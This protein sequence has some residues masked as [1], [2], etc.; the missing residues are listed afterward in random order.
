MTPGVRR[1]G[2]PKGT[3]IDD[4]A[5]LSRIGELM[6]ADPELK[7][8]TA[9]KRAGVDNPSIVRRLREKLKMPDALVMPRD[10]DRSAAPPGPPGSP[11]KTRPARPQR[12]P[13][14]PPGPDARPPSPPP[15]RPVPAALPSAARTRA[16]TR[17]ASRLAS[18][19]K[20]V[21]PRIATLAG[22]G[23]LTTQIPA[24]V[25][26]TAR[27]AEATTPPPTPPPRNDDGHRP[28]APPIGETAAAPPPKTAP[29]TPPPA[30]VQPPGWVQIGLTAAS[31]A[32]QLQ[33]MVVSQLLNTPETRQFIERQLMFNQRLWNAALDYLSPPSAKRTEK[34]SDVA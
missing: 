6:A 9:I 26:I 30:G 2:R 11:T 19:Q 10:A 1:R 14:P 34:N 25:P 23:P 16:S 22:T 21:A 20:P 27:P 31:S 17:L 8:T 13:A 5:I 32:M 7:P 24:S 33:A 12:V 29:P 4:R 28:P 15:S 3:G 18:R